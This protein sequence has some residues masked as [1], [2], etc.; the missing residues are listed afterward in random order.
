MQR[1]ILFIF[2]GLTILFAGCMGRF[3]ETETFEENIDFVTDGEIDVDSFNGSISVESWD[4]SVVQ[5][6]AHKKVTAKSYRHAEARLKQLHVVV[7]HD[8]DKLRIYSQMDKKKDSGFL[9][10]LSQ[11]GYSVEYHIKVPEGTRVKA[12]TTNGGITIR[13][14][15]GAI[16]VKS[17]NGGIDLYRV[18]E[19]LDAKTTNGGIETSVT[20]FSASGDIKLRS[21]NGGISLDLPTEVNAE[22]RAKTTNGRVY[23]DFELMGEFGSDKNRI[24]GTLGN[25]GGR[26]ELRTTNGDVNVNEKF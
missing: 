6:V 16:D 18:G 22:F 10:F 7:T 24:S 3:Q 14:V 21:T 13:R 15:H 5:V 2:V 4:Q 23:L 9:G 17:V 26:I 19:V 11:V 1:R 8:G 20:A 12:R 25:G